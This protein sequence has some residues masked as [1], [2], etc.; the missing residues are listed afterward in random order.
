MPEP[1]RALADVTPEWLTAALAEGGHLPRGRVAL[2][3]R[4]DAITETAHVSRLHLGYS[5]DADV[6]PPERLFL[7]LAVGQDPAA[8]RLR[9]ARNEACFYRVLAE[10]SVSLPVPRCYVVATCQAA[11]SAYYMVLADIAPTHRRAAGAAPDEADCQRA[12]E[13]LARIHAHW[14]DHPRLREGLADWPSARW[15]TVEGERAYAADVAATLPG[16]LDML[17]DALS[18]AWRRRYERVVAALPNLV[19][20]VARDRHITLIHGDAHLGNALYPRDPAGEALWIDWQ[21][22]NVSI[23]AHDLRHTI[24]RAWDRERR[25][26]LERPLLR[27]YYAALQAHGVTGFTWEMLWDDY[28][29]GAIDNLFM[30]MWQWSLDMPTA[31]W[32]P[33]LQRVMEAYEDLECEALVKSHLD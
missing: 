3:A 16:Y 11:P 32:R 20:R 29:L 8:L 4:D 33:M 12:I 1:I 2:L 5:P 24:A 17:G 30:P 18:P 22:W 23:A 26:R 27:H 13:G 7:K 31:W 21:F 14:W 15:P 10:A 28:R 6:H 25:A 9:L 19:A